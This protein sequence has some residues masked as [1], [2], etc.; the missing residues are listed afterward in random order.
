MRPKQISYDVNNLLPAPCRPQR[1]RPTRI[2]SG[3]RKAAD[4]AK[5][6][7]IPVILVQ[8]DQDKLVPVAGPK[9]VAK[10]AALVGRVRQRGLLL[11][12]NGTTGAEDEMRPLLRY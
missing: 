7:H 8:G 1:L 3:F 4:V 9:W 6:K 12:L 5:V 11:H 10:D 2:G